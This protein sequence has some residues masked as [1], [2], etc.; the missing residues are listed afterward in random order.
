MKEF[1]LEESAKIV[2]NGG[3][4]SAL[5]T[6]TSIAEDGLL[7]GLGFV[8]GQKIIAL[9]GERVISSHQ[10]V[11]SML[12]RSDEAHVFALLDAK[13]AGAIKVV[14]LPQDIQQN[15]NLNTDG[16]SLLGIGLSEE[17]QPGETF[18]RDVGVFQ[19]F[20]RALHQTWN[21]GYLTAK[22]FWLLI[23]GGVSSKNVGGPIM[24][25]DVAQQAAKKG[26]EYYIFIMCLIS[27]NLGI[28]N[29][30]PVPALDG[31]HLLLFGIEAVQRKPVSLRTRTIATQVGVF[32][33]LSLMAFALYN[34]L[35]R[36]FG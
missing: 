32:L 24:L 35:S 18:I 29:L 25:F 15:V 12:A 34:D 23:T 9:N 3:I 7:A 8:K 26:I 1:L 20:G 30:L 10:L 16:Q 27:V 11:Q 2:A 28:L 17:Y 31:G 21:V 36:L 19:A 33:L 6:I 4:T 22:S 14:R 5:A 13:L